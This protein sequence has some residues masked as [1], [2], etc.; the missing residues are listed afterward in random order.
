MIIPG[1]SK[2]TPLDPNDNQ[3]VLQRILTKL[4]EATI[5]IHEMADQDYELEDSLEEALKHLEE[6]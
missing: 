5:A 3:L 1:A 6:E 4:Q 2:N